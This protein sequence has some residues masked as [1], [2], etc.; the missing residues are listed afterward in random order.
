MVLGFIRSLWR[1]E[2]HRSREGTLLEMVKLRKR[3]DPRLRRE[4]LD[5]WTMGQLWHSPEGVMLDLTE[6]YVWLMDAGL[7][8]RSALEQLERVNCGAGG[9]AELTIGAVLVDALRS[10]DPEL[11][12]DVDLLG[13]QLAVGFVWARQEVQRIK[14][15]PPYPRASLHKRICVEDVSEVERG[16]ADWPRIEGRITE[17]DQLW[18]F[19]GPGR[20]GIV[21]IRGDRAIARVTTVHFSPA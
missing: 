5:L 9:L 16:L 21:L 10:V 19:A 1:G 18:R 20:S 14:S 13:Q 7:S 17:R 8:E 3:K 4:R 12:L 15:E 2:R 11:V 6:D